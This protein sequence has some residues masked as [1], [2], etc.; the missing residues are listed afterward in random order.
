M[1]LCRLLQLNTMTE[2]RVRMFHITITI[3]TILSRNRAEIVCKGHYGTGGDDANLQEPELEWC[4][5]GCNC[6][7]ISDQSVCTDEGGTAPPDH[8][9]QMV[10]NGHWGPG[11]NGNYQ[12]PDLQWCCV[13][14]N[15]MDIWD[16]SPCTGDTLTAGP[17]A[18]PSARTDTPTP[19]PTRSPTTYAQNQALQPEKSQETDS[20]AAVIGGVTA[21][22]VFIILLLIG[23]FIC[24]RRKKSKQSELQ[25]N[26]TVN[27][28]K[29]EQEGVE[30]EVPETNT[31]YM[32][33]TN[34][35]YEH[36]S[37]ISTAIPTIPSVQLVENKCVSEG[38]INEQISDNVNDKQKETVEVKI[39]EPVASVDDKKENQETVEVKIV[40]PVVSVAH[41]DDKKENQETSIIPNGT[42]CYV[43]NQSDCA[44][45]TEVIITN[46]LAS[47]KEYIVKIANGGS[48]LFVNTTDV[49]RK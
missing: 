28:S 43:F 48:R 37:N 23:Y 7:D 38:V 21:A 42:G 49:E 3:C 36:G 29:H 20:D 5:I 4:C 6:R 44:D 22:V 41:V 15:C 10:C 11:A 39:V 40:E 14:C 45:G 35:T 9:G 16:R 18:H 46:Y 33:E 32:Q 30:Q 27:V 8:E 47:S 31:T 13:S 26:D 24:V 17:T 25:L 19:R 2:M 34:D 1:F 12:E